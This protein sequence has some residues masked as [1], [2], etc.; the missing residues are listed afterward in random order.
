M[1]RKA[2]R[3]T[4]FSTF[5]NNGFMRSSEIAS[6]WDPR[7]QQKFYRPY[8]RGTYYID[9]NIDHRNI[10]RDILCSSHHK[11]VGLL[12]LSSDTCSQWQS[13]EAG[14]QRRTSSWTLSWIVAPPIILFFI[15]HLC[16]ATG[17]R[18][19]LNSSLKYQCS[20]P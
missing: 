11:M 10:G 17:L 12:R 3:K 8:N 13:P 5:I 16:W 6:S 14:A 19:Q 15:I 20:H 2:D 18:I 1:G 4:D 7:D 9:R